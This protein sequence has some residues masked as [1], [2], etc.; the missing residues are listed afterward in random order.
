MITPSVNP[1]DLLV[2][3]LIGFSGFLGL[4]R[5]FTRGF[6]GTLSWV[7]ASFLTFWGKYYFQGIMRPW[8][9]HGLLADFI[10][11]VVLFL[12]SLFILLSLTRALS[13]RVK[14]SVLGGVD[15]SLGFIFGV[16][17]GMLICV[18]AFLLL[19][20]TVKPHKRPEDLKKS[21]S[22]PFL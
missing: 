15:R 20:V 11:I 13:L 2:L 6:F 9:G 18:T 19:N 3:V 4:V 22:Y 14:A 8:V 12:T 7:G 21:L 1:Y 10:T 5:G 17:R 16:G